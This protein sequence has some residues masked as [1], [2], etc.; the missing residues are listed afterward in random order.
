MRA[1]YNQ[2]SDRFIDICVQI[3]HQKYKLINKNIYKYCVTPF[4]Y[5]N[6]M[7]GSLILNTDQNRQEFFTQLQ[8]YIKAKVEKKKVVEPTEKKPSETGYKSSERAAL[9]NQLMQIESVANAIQEEK[10]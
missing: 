1:L 9:E 10:K 8:T 2:Y 7:M 4:S 5:N 6:G 3:L